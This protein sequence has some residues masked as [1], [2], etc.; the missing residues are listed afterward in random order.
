MDG[1]DN[2]KGGYMFF[3]IYKGRAK[4]VINFNPER[5]ELHLRDVENAGGNI[6][7]VGY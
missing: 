1:Y 6:V 3:L 4:T 2:V 5:F 7:Y